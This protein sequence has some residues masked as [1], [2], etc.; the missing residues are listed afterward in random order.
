MDEGMKG[1]DELS[2][3]NSKSKSVLDGSKRTVSKTHSFC[4]GI[5]IFVYKMYKKE[6][7]SYQ[8]SA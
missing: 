6:S 4:A 1:R 8:C 5:K 7:R 2:F 3:Q